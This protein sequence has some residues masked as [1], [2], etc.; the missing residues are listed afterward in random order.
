M[1][2]KPQSGGQ[3]RATLVKKKYNFNHYSVLAKASCET[4][5]RFHTE[6]HNTALY[7][8]FVTA[9]HYQDRDKTISTNPA[10]A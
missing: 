3:H 10:K 1:H 2:K 4:F 6:V 8:L 7:E 9:Y 5:L